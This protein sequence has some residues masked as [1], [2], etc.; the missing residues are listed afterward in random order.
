MIVE[1]LV[2]YQIHVTTE[3]KSYLERN[4]Y[5]PITKKLTQKWT[6]IFHGLVFFTHL[7]HDSA[8]YLTANI[9][10]NFVSSWPLVLTP[11]K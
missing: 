5:K 10:K 9:S 3:K 7:V 2:I 8:Y 11:L 1:W 4:S 6:S